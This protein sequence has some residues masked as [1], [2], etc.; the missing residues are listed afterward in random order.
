MLLASSDQVL[1]ECDGCGA[2]R[3]SSA[4][5]GWYD[6]PLDPPYYTGPRRLLLCPVC[7]AALPPAQ[8]RRW[9]CVGRRRP[10]PRNAAVGRPVL[11]VTLLPKRGSIG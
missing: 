7:F 6:R 3:H 10:T 5:H 8:Q 2:R 11:S 1:T 4:P 9:R